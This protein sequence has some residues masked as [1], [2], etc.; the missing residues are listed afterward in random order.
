MHRSSP[1]NITDD[2]HV[3]A[4]IRGVPPAIKQSIVALKMGKST[5]H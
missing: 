3:R 4:L 5:W 1:A 2:P